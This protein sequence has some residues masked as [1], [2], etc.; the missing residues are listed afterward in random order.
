MGHWMLMPTIPWLQALPTGKGKLLPELAQDR[1][2]PDLKRSPDPSPVPKPVQT[3]LLPCWE[4]LSPQLHLPK[5]PF[6]PY[7]FRLKRQ[8]LRVPGVCSMLSSTADTTHTD[9]GTTGCRESPGGCP[10]IA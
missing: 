7:E 6:P 8:K 1:A 5:T 4:T 9:D 10:G 3:L 2:P